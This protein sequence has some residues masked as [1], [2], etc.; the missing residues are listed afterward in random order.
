MLK[1]RSWVVLSLGCVLALLLSVLPAQAQGAV[2]RAVLFYSPSC[3][4]CHKVITEDLPP[5]FEKYGE[6][7]QTIDVDTSQPG[8][9]ALY[10]AAAHRFKIPQSNRVCRCSLSATGPSSARWI[11]RSSSPA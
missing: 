9:Q 8:G 2:V 7:L 4:H 11:S 5:L 1:H 10:Q 6:R 3:G